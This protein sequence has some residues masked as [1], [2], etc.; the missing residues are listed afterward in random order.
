[1]R[2]QTLPFA[3]ALAGQALLPLAFAQTRPE[4]SIREEQVR[5]GSIVRRILVGPA[6][7]ALN[8]PYEKL[9]EDD[10]ARFHQQY[11]EIRPGDEPPFPVGGLKS[12]LDPIRMAQ[13]VFLVKDN[14]FLVARIDSTGKTTEI[15]SIE[16][17]TPQMTKFAAQVLA[18]TKFK[19]AVCSG[20][21]CAMEFPLQVAF[22]IGP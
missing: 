16:A 7:I 4:Y 6:R 2:I 1:M 13:Q 15:F 21:P 22:R 14:L 18:A 20:A 5:T 19:P 12:I 17:S 3:L 9:S 11:E 10:R 8:L